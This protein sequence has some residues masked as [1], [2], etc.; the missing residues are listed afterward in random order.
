MT[1]FEYGGGGSTLFFLSKVRRVHTVEHDKEWFESIEGKIKSRYGNNW[2]GIF[3]SPELIE[4]TDAQRY[5][6]PTQ[7]TSSDNQFI[8]FSFKKYAESIDKFPDNYF[9]L[10][11]VDGRSRPSCLWHGIPKVKPGGLL[12]LDNSERDYYLQDSQLLNA[13][14]TKFNVMESSHSPQPFS[15][16]FTTTTVWR[17]IGNHTK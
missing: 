5:S 11:M 17:K 16:H 6:D 2:D 15:S 13:I 3:V 7:Y 1:V 4:T 12:V 9:D 10:V 14:N 8:N